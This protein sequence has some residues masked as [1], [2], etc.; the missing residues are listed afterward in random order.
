MKVS[1]RDKKKITKFINDFIKDQNLAQFT[2][3]NL[4]FIDDGHETA[5][6]TITIHDQEKEFTI[7]IYTVYCENYKDMLFF[8][9][10]ELTHLYLYEMNTYH[11]FLTRNT[12]NTILASEFIELYEKIT[13][14]VAKIFYNIYTEQI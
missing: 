8:L 4:I 5:A 14:Q 6:A 7:R 1:N 10:H 2:M 13:C 9:I 3:R 12:E 11:G